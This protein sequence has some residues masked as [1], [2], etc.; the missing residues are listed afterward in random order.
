MQNN[1]KI[2]QINDLQKKNIIKNKYL[3]SYLYTY[4]PVPIFKRLLRSSL[5]NFIIRRTGLL[6]YKE[7][8]APTRTWNWENLRKSAL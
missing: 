1:I 7:L 5:A 6:Y 4:V 8:V 3:Y 2:I